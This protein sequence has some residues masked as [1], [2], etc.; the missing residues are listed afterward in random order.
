[1]G[2]V[3]NG[4]GSLNITEPYQNILDDADANFHSSNNAL[5]NVT[6]HTNGQE[7]TERNINISGTIE[8]GEVLVNKLV[9]LVGSTQFTTNV[10]TD[11]RFNLPISLEQGINHFQFMT[12]GYNTEG[13]QISVPN[14]MEEEDFILNLN[15]P[16]AAILV[17]LTWDTDD[18]DVD[19]YV[20]DPTGDYSA[21]YHKTTSDGGELDHDI[22][23]GYGPEHWTLLTTN[24]IHY[25]Q[26]YK[27]R[28]HYYSDHGNG[29]TN[30]TVSIKLYEGTSREQE[31]WYRGNLSTYGGYSN[32]APN[33]TGADWI[34]IAN[35]ILTQDISGAG[36]KITQLPNSNINI[37]SQIPT[38]EERKK[39]KY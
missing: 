5:I 10:G 20:I 4:D 32:N 37:T 14:S 13:N 33:A 1:Q 3:Y 22:T 28:L 8:S 31:Y 21:Y 18:T 17:T 34:D 24:I 9:I 36:F 38:E 25:D 2:I 35:I 26:P 16:K 11:G 39:Y 23:S 12:Y 15:I 7:I 29:P 30:Y 6:S 27:V 19:L